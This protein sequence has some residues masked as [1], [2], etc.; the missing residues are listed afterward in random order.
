MHALG[1]K[2][3]DT[4]TLPVLVEHALC[5]Q[6]PR[7]EDLNSA[8]DVT[9]GSSKIQQQMFAPTARRDDSLMKLMFKAV[10]NVQPD[11]M[12]KTLVQSMM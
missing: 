9:L 10:S 2:L 4:T 7:F 8:K 3:V 12:P 1:V 5:V 11:T 6:P